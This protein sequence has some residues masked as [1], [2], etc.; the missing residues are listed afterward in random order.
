VTRSQVVRGLSALLVACAGAVLVAQALV[1]RAGER[2]YHAL[3][4]AQQDGRVVP[5]AR[6]PAGAYLAALGA[7]RA[8]ARTG[9]ATRR[10]GARAAAYTDA[11]ALVEGALAREQPP[12]QRSRLET[13]AG[14]LEAQLRALG[15][16]GAHHGRAAARRLQQAVLDDDTND[17]AK[18][19][20]ELL[21]RRDPESARKQRQTQRTAAQP[22]KTNRRKQKA[23]RGLSTKPS[24]LGTGF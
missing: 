1:A 18:Y 16:R 7:F 15:G 11:L 5:R 21:I 24:R 4:Q 19:D 2:R 12:A 13:L 8:A 3:E 23:T 22:K 10:S 6:T 20:L 17:D 14:V 9:H